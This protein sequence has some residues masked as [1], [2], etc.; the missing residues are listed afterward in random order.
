MKYSV[1]D[2]KTGE[3]LRTFTNLKD[4]HNYEDKMI[5]EFGRPT[6]GINFVKNE[7]VRILRDIEQYYST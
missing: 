6:F 1:V 7:D 2:T 5:K 3:T 4:A